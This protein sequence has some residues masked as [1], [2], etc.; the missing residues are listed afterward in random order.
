MGKLTAAIIRKI[1]PTDKNQRFTDGA[2]LAMV[3]RPDGSK[4]WRL[5]L[6]GESGDR[7]LGRFPDITCSE[8]R[9]KAGQMKAQHEKTRVKEKV[10]A[11]PSFA[12]V[13]ELY[14]A[15]NEPTWKHRKTAADTRSSLETYACPAF[16]ARSI[17]T[18]R[19]GDVFAM[20]SAIWTAKPATAKKLKQRVR[21]VFVYALARDWIVVN[22]VDDAI[23][24]A[25]PK[26]PA[27]KA[28]LRAMPYQ[29]VKGAL[30][31]VDASASGPAVKLCARWVVLTA[32][33][34]GEARAA[35]W[36]DI[37]QRGRTWTIPAERM[38]AGKE[39]RVPLSRQ[40]L[41]VLDKARAIEDGSGWIFPS[42]KAKPLSDMSLTKLLR[43]NGL[44][45]KATVHGFRTSFKTWCM[46]TT[47]TP[48]AV[49]EAA[50]AH[51]LGNSTEQAYARSDLFERRRELMQTWADF[52]A[53]GGQHDRI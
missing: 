30:Q 10:D 22:P 36:E 20:L 45:A 7:G 21:A 12:Q 39:H 5:R 13:A 50:L 3:V 53:A 33:R 48:W 38:K 27:I 34:S 46:E 43:D 8:A 31:V 14:I 40:A 26:T 52:A 32:V 25:L 51:T 47:D 49:G 28:H 37:D 6:P 24:A 9:R 44:A 16:G 17:D 2:G 1:K 11:V 15:A 18:I 41:E 42:S 19:R 4:A 23:D 29:E 35:R